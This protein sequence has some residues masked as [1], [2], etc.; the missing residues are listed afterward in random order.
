MTLNLANRVREHRWIVFFCLVFLTAG[1]LRLNDLSLFTD[2][3]RYVIWGTSFAHARGFVDDTQPDPERYV[4][5]APL[6]SVLIAP[7]L[8]L[9]PSS[10]LAA[11]VWTLLWGIGFIV[12]FYAMLRYFFSKAAATFG[13]LPVVFH[14][15]F[16]L[17]STEVLTESAFLT[18]VSVGFLALERLEQDGETNKRDVI[19]LLLVTSFIVLLREVAIALVGCI[20]LYLLARKQYKEPCWFW[21]ALLRSLEHGST[22]TSSSLGS[23]RFQ[24]TNLSYVFEH[25]LTPTQAPLLQEFGFRIVNNVI[26]YAI[27]LAGLLFYPLPDALIVEPSGIFLC[28]FPRDDHRG[29]FLIPL[30]FVPVLYSELARCERAIHGICPYPVRRRLPS[31]HSCVSCARH[32]VSSPPSSLS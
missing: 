27:H 6:Y 29:S 13:I 9:F 15:L 20:L 31:D 12:A 11:K 16:L 5:N 4:V 24:A 1:A 26:G 32:P 19:I 30:I 21:S 14:P 18:F 17:L 10:L 28:L 3:T 22:E 2:S 25:F 7:A 23:P 8:L